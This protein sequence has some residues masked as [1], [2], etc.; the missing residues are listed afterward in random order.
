M[1]KLYVAGEK[2]ALLTRDTYII[3]T[4]GLSV[5]PKSFISPEQAVYLWGVRDQSAF[6]AHERAPYKS[7]GI[8]CHRHICIHR[9][10][11]HD[12]SLILVIYFEDNFSRAF[13]GEAS[14]L[15]MC[16]F[17]HLSEWDTIRAVQ[18]WWHHM[19]LCNRGP[20]LAY[21]II[22][23]WFKAELLMLF[24]KSEEIP[25]SDLMRPLQI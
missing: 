14:G 25:W 18:W 17:T 23:S 19:E 1:S 21:H 4:N 10:F 16:H 8:M 20:L 3:H 12:T 13:S 11:P 24:V 2:N 6:Q 22:S 15:K 7:Q 5:A 9:I